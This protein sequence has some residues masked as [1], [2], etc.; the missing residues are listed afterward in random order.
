MPGLKPFVE[1]G[2]DM[3]EHD[4]QFDR[5]GLQRDSTGWT[6]KAGSTFAFSRKL[7]GEIALGYLER[8]YKDPSLQQLQG[9]LFDASLIYSLSALTNIKLTA[10]TVAGETTVPGTA[11]IL[12]RNAG[13][14]VEHAFRRWL[15]GAVKFNYGN[16][17]YVGST[18]KDDRF[19][20][21]AALTYKLNRLMQVKGEV[22]QEWLNSTVPGV[23][24]TATILLLGLRLQR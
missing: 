12:T 1:V 23:D 2:A 5:F 4:L 19:A 13:I 3:R 18:R 9:V 14:E 22:R 20:I 6:A 15:I 10:A 11:G 24:Y 8:N 16:D 17:D 21:S 7:T